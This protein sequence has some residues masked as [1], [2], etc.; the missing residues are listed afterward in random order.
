MSKRKKYDD[1]NGWIIIDKPRDMTSNM[2]VNIT[3]RI[4]NANKNGHTGT[5]DPFATGVLPIAFGEA[6]KLIPFVTD[7][8][9]EY[10][11]IVKWGASTN[12]D[13]S[14]GDVIASTNNIPTKA[15][16]LKTIP[17]FIGKIKQIP[18]MYSAIK[19]NGERA[20]S[21][22]RQGQEVDMPEREIEIYDLELLEMLP[23]NSSKFRVR[24]SKGTY[25]R[26]LGKDIALKLGSLG[27]LKELR[28][29]KCGVF[30]LNDK[31]LLE[32]LKNMVYKEELAR[33]LLP[34]ETSLRDI[35]VIAV[36]EGDAAKLKQGQRISP[37]NYDAGHLIGSG[38]V[39]VFNDNL[40]AIVGVE[41]SR[42]SP[43]RVFNI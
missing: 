38:A 12:T 33:V 13:D 36:S 29:T 43:L 16:I 42:I 37:K 32:S 28:R 25:V 24:C 21:L 27:Y 31:I 40:V 9:K 4:F 18:P 22:A 20:Y 26:T 41:E 10:E 17:C 2:V 14:E 15:E 6:T 30:S 11:F 3:R 7:G 34:I 23:D 19:I 5:L 35:A 39:A 1:V 8:E